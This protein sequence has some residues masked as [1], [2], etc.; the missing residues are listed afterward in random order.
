V[1][2]DRGRE[3]SGQAQEKAGQVAGQAQEKAGQAAGQAQEKVGQVAG[4]AQEKA[5]EVADQARGRLQDQLDQRSRDIGQ[6]LRSSAGAFRSASSQLRE[7]G[8][9]P[10]A[11][12]IERGADQVERLGSYLERASGH[13]L[14]DDV[15]NLGRRNPWAVILSGATLGFAAARMLRASSSKRYEQRGQGGQSGQSGQGTSPYSSDYGYRQPGHEL[16]R[17]RTA[18]YD[19][20]LATT[21]VPPAPMDAPPVRTTPGTGI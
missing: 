14:L 2:G 11:N 10:A 4:Q 12:L 21:P 17:P 19:D 6:Q 5:S 16:E 15:E 3:T 1:A 9:A 8:P 18:V 7:Q 20:D 13:Q